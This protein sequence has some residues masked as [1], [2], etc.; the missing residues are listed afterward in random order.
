MIGKSNGVRSL[1]RQQHRVA[2]N[3]KC[4]QREQ[5]IQTIVVEHVLF[6]ALI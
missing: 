3:D 1:E 2:I 5:W 4:P 6:R